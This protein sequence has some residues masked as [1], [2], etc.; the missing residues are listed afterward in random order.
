[1]LALAVLAGAAAAAAAIAPKPALL[2]ARASARRAAAWTRTPCGWVGNK[3]SDQITSWGAAL[4]PDAVLQEYPRPQHTRPAATYTNLNGLWEFELAAGHV[5]AARNG[6][7]DT[8]PPFGRTLNQ[9]ILVPFP[10]ESCLSGAYAW[11]AYSHFL[12]YRALFDAPPPA[13]GAVTLLHFGAVDWNATIYV[14]GAQLLTHVG[15]YDGF[16]VPLANLAAANN[17]LIVAVYDPSETG[18]QPHG[19]QVIGDIAHPGGDTYTPSSG[20]WQTVWLETVP[21]YRV[22]ELRVRGDT[23][24]VYVTATT[25]PPTAGTATVEVSLAGAVVARAT[26]ATGAQ[27]V[28]PVPSPSLWS[29]DTPTLY[30]VAV[31]VADV[32][33]GKT[34]SVGSYVGMR[35]VGTVARAFPG[36]PATGPRVGMDNSGGDMP[37]QPTVLP[38]ADYNLCYAMCNATAGC[39][40]WSYG[41]PGAGCEAQPLCWLKAQIEGWSTNACRVAGDKATPGGSGLVL[42]VNGE[43]TFVAG[44]LDQSWWPDGEYTAP[45]DDA[46]AFDVAA[47][48]TFGLN[49]VRLHQKVNSERWYYAADRLGVYV[50]QDAVQKYGGASAATIPAFMSDLKAMMD[51]RGN[52]PSIIQWEIF[53]EGDC[54]GVFPNVSDVIAWAQAYD[55]FRLV[56]TN[57]GGPANDLRV[58][59][60]FDIHSYPWPGSPTPTA[61]QYAMV[62]EFGGIGAFIPGHEWAPHQCSTYL[63]TD[64][65][66][67]EADT[68]VNMTAKLIAYKATGV[69]VSI[70]TQLSDVENECDGF[71]NMDRTSKFTA[72]QTA[73]IKAAN[74]ALIAA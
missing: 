13:G 68:Y 59:N 47:I 62:G 53:N 70:Y 60:V 3:S 52:H 72:A 66:Q 2:H 21:D 74:A 11:P 41:V 73:Q 15:G 67:E 65:A 54:V 49:G 30:D 23:A 57:S 69:S 40:A 8:P 17:E 19:K 71:F 45:S 7:F 42:A 35:A 29:A 48:K 50:L 39:A 37:G 33:T 14:N 46:L 5:D 9:T 25:V 32:A 22:A 34:D 61:T 51:G 10:L 64:T 26:G 28:V 18:Y 58:G 44:W 56:D 20:I 43:P 63:H 55:P 12:F 27:V 4:D 36:V 1:M 16:S 6:V 24:N 38:R 31:T